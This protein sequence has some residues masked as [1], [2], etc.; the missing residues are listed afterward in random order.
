MVKSVERKFHSR[1]SGTMQVIT[2][3]EELE[4]LE[5]GMW[6]AIYARRSREIFQVC[7]EGREPIGKDKQRVF[8]KYDLEIPFWPHAEEMPQVIEYM[9]PRRG[10]ILIEDF[11]KG[12]IKTHGVN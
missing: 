12:K 1:S 6:P 5:I 7:F 4:K 2:R 11:E 9:L 10:E 3:Y 8:L